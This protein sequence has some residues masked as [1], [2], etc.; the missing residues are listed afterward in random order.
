LL[1]MIDALSSFVGVLVG[2]GYGYKYVT[3]RGI[4]LCI[5]WFVGLIEGPRLED[6][7]ILGVTLPEGAWSESWESLLVGLIEVPRLED[8]LVLGVT[9]AEGVKNA[10]ALIVGIHNTIIRPASFSI[11]RICIANVCNCVFLYENQNSLYS[12]CF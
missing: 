2:K 3:R 4:A 7:L 10:S 8:G 5:C 1:L 9:F 12:N 11:S 6:G